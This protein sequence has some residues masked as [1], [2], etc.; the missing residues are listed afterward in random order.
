M[1]LVAPKWLK[2]LPASARLTL[3]DVTITPIFYDL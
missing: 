3:I 1:L 2:R